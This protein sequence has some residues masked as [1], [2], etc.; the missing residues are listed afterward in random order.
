MNFD[1]VVDKRTELL[2]VLLL[3]SDYNK[4]CPHLIEEL[5]NKDYRENIF[6][7]FSKFKEDKTVKLFNRL[8]NELNFSYDAP[9][10]LF[11][12]LKEDF[13]FDE[14]EEYPFYNRLQKSQLVLD[15]LNELPEFANRIEFK[16]F[17]KD[18]LGFYQE[19]IEKT[20]LHSNI[21]Q[22]TKFMTD[23]YKMD[24]SKNLLKVNLL[25][26]ATNGGFGTTIKNEIVCHLGLKNNSEPY[27]FLA[28]DDYGSMLLHEFS[29]SIINPLTDK[30]CTF[31]GGQ[32]AD[33]W[34]QMKN[35]S[36][37]SVYCIVNEHIIRA[38][39][40][41][42]LKEIIKTEKS[43]K[44]ADFRLCRDLKNCFKYIETCVNSIEYYYQNIDKYSNFEE[45]FPKILSEIERNMNLSINANK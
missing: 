18:N 3:I 13:T 26:Y 42:H 19:I 5:Y 43:L 14:L 10:S 21:D 30:Y 34:E 11:L 32:F 29:H 16:Q 22:I 17:Y 2:G 1:V 7:R 37:G 33:I 25:P 6:N 27:T 24:L 28:E 9:V 20:K 35:M 38:L 45:Y 31:K 44:K 15:F 8:I 41:F 36:Y 23:F 39:Q 12:Q 4:I 40:I